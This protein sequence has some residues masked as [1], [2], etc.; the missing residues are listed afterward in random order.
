[1]SSDP[2]ID[3]LLQHL[4][5]AIAR[6]ET[7]SVNDICRD[8]PDL[9]SAVEARLAAEGRFEPSPTIHDERPEPIP[10]AKMETGAEPVPG[11][12][13]TRYIDGGGFG[14]VW[15]AAGPGRFPVAMKFV[16]LNA[17][18]GEIEL[19]ALEVL[20][21]IRHPNLLATFG[22]WQ[23]ENRLIIAMELAEG[24]L[25]D[26]LRQARDQRL[27]GIPAEE[28]LGYMADAAR[29]IDFLNAPRHTIE[30][31]PN[32]G[33][34][35]RDIKPQNLLLVGGG[36]KV[37]DFGL[38]Q[39][40]ERSHADHSGSLTPSYAA[41]EFFDGRTAHSSDQYSLA[42]TYCQLRG[43][44]VPFT[45][46]IAQVMKGHLEREPDLGMLP[47][48][49]RPA[50][51]RALSKD[52]EARWPSCKAFVAG[53]TAP[54][55]APVIHGQ[56]AFREVRRFPAA[57]G[58]VVDLAFLSD[59]RHAITAGHDARLIVWD[60]W[61]GREAGR[62]LGHRDLVFAVA[63]SPDGKRVL[64]VSDDGTLRLWDVRAR[65][66][67]QVMRD[68]QV[69]RPEV[70][71]LTTVAFSPS[72]VRA[73]V[74]SGEGALLLYGLGTLAQPAGDPAPGD[75]EYRLARQPLRALKDD[76]GCVWQAAF[77]PA[78]RWLAAGGAHLSV[79]DLPEQSEARR[80]VGH[81]EEVYGV[82]FVPGG[83]RLVSG[84]ADGTVRLWDAES[85][86]EL[87]CFEGHERSVFSVCVAPDGRHALS[88]GADGTLRLW[89]LPG[90]GG[91]RVGEVHRV[92]AHTDRIRCVTF[93]PDGRHALSSD[94]QGVKLWEF[95][96]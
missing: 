70:G 54:P 91:E 77:A 43:G 47:A 14:E 92:F 4:H 12:R 75:P 73:A 5:D 25:H 40:L 38:A 16:R 60:V 37:A 3:E 11:Y 21:S 45:G 59:G 74:G 29:A 95:V 96:L 33:V 35:H 87:H 28:L 34:Q 88:A 1:M 46:T 27:T 44:R 49:E 64:S 69:I 51:A 81:T 50:V 19:R 48:S 39:V 26:R 66:E 90:E 15:E 63:V 24:T 9:R 94:G 2:A 36:L 78:G 71:K 10:P 20:R 86:R 89:R 30:G 68:A 13:L 53:L 52:P 55:P 8:R 83:S 42:V 41:P 93:A 72:G 67:L 56:P 6:G 57:A 32:V 85:G 58:G 62:L 22:T 65:R 61:E 17:R 80:L 23:S 84:A 31:H 82:A 18:T 7:V 79:W 76:K